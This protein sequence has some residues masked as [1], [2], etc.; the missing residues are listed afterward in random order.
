M[1]RR[2]RTCLP[3]IVA[4]AKHPSINRRRTRVVSCLAVC[5]PD[6]AIECD[7]IHNYCEPGSAD[8]PGYYCKVPA[9]G[10]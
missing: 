1:F 2:S 7:Y 5:S 10:T 6:E 3:P 4:L 9:P 8:A